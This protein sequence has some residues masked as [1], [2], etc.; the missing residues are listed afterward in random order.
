M[1]SN[2]ENHCSFEK[3]WK[4]K[5]IKKAPSLTL[6][7]FKAMWNMREIIRKERYKMENNKKGD[8]YLGSVVRIISDKALIIDVV[9]D[10]LTIWDKVQIYTVLDEIK[11][12]EGNSLGLYENIKD[13]LD[14]TQTAVNYSIC[15]KIITKKTSP[16]AGIADALAGS[17]YTVSEDLNVNKNE[18]EPLENNEKDKQIHVGDYVKKYWIVLI[19]IL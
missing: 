8:N 13:T 14:V 1:L 2:I 6:G 18:I 3:N 12:L 4:I 17:E 15:E 7:H 10:Y 11:D 19:S 5:H 9:K 16:Y